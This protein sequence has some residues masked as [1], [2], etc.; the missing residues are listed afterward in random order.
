MLKI[1]HS[2]GN[3]LG[4]K[5]ALALFAASL[6]T[7]GVTS[8]AFSQPDGE[9]EGE[10]EGDDDDDDAGDDGD[11]GGE[12]YEDY[13]DYDDPGTG[14]GDESVDA[15]WDFGSAAKGGNR[16]DPSPDNLVCDGGWRYPLVETRSEIGPARFARQDDLQRDIALTAAAF[17]YCETAAANTWGKS[18]AISAGPCF[19]LLRLASSLDVV[20]ANLFHDDQA[21]ACLT[22]TANAGSSCEGL[23]E[24]LTTVRSYDQ[25]IVDRA[26]LVL[27]YEVCGS[28]ERTTNRDIREA[29][30]ALEGEVAAEYGGGNA[31]PGQ[32][33]LIAPI[34]GRV[35][36]KVRDISNL[37]DGRFLSVIGENYIGVRNSICEMDEAPAEKNTCELRPLEKT[38]PAEGADAQLAMWGTKRAETLWGMCNE[39]SLADVNANTCRKADVYIDERGELHLNS[40][41]TT[42]GQRENATMCI[43]ISDFDADHPLM[44]TLGMEPTSSVPER[45]WPGETMRIGKLIDRKVTR[46]DILKIHVLG[47]ARGISLSEVLRVNGVL[48]F[49]GGREGAKFTRSSAQEACRIARSWVP[50]VDHE[51]PIG[52]R[53]KQAVIPVTFSRGRDGETKRISQ[54]DYVLLWVRDIE[55]SGSVLAQYAAGQF[56]GYEPPPLVGGTTL[57]LEMRDHR[58]PA[59]NGTIQ[60]NSKRAQLRSGSAGVD[61]PLLPRRA[62]YPGSRV[63]RLGSPE[64]NHRYDLK[65]CTRSGPAPKAVAAAAIAAASYEDDEEYGDEDLGAAATAT[66]VEGLTCDGASVILDEKIFV[67]GD[68][69][70]GVGLYFGYSLFPID[71]FTARKTPAAMA[72]GPNTYEVVQTSSQKADYDVAAMLTIYPGGRDPHDFTLNPLSKRYWKHFG[73]MMG[74]TVRKLT[75]WN[76]FYLGGSL[77]VANGVSLSTLAH[78]SRRSIPTDVDAGDL[79]ESTS[80]NP[81]ISTI[82]SSKNVL[83]VGLSVGLT[84]DFDLFERA[85]S[86][87]WNKLAG[88]GQFTATSN[89]RLSA[90][91]SGY[92]ED[93]GGYDDYDGG[94][95]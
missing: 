49:G 29:C 71:E 67:H 15:G 56:V 34:P 52:D 82:F 59:G 32:F 9:G 86:G 77:P 31:A 27:A 45:I 50:V 74:F 28:P 44:V 23:R 10:G 7:F 25:I 70:F 8:P 46:E 80:S 30:T 22:E 58:G 51:V 55:P 26:E 92:D 24:Q 64:G 35:A 19:G 39:L 84:L 87:M 17:G 61:E 18:Y 48:G 60:P 94:D 57:S 81:D 85:F 20:A 3:R 90:A 72:V 38:K 37:T 6:L 65:V 54:G 21:C 42:R 40:P 12:D 1:A 93:G 16:S 33:N 36:D 79:F 66:P 11:G 14:P 83:A 95:E 4:T 89:S 69:H 68:Y 41:L 62:R 75:P 53:E 13:E 91:P 73:L 88:K 5:L 47:K 2:G 76:D 63:L 43:D 78:F